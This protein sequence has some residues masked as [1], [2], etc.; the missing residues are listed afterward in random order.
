MGIETFGVPRDLAVVLEGGFRLVD[1]TARK[2]V[3]EWLDDERAT[4]LILSG[5]VGTG[6]TLAAAEAVAIFWDESW[7]AEP[8]SPKRRRA[9]PRWVTARDL[10]RYAPWDAPAEWS[11]AG[12][13]VL[14][15]L[16]IEEA[17]PQTLAHIDGLIVG[18][19]ADGL[20]TIITTNMAA[21]AK[22]PDDPPGFIDR[23]KNRITD[24]LR[25]SGLHRGKAR[26][27]VTCNGE[28]MRGRVEPTPPGDEG[29]EDA[30]VP[31]YVPPDELA[32]ATKKLAESD[33]TRTSLHV[34]KPPP[35]SVAAERRGKGAVADGDADARRKLR[36]QVEARLRE[37]QSD[38]DDE[39]QD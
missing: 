21:K 29:L 12:L 16:G 23:Y 32:K 5:T 26:Y 2:A 14:D 25:A 28:S 10:G 1:T 37:S 15:D 39:G 8:F 38:G 11:T 3:R 18:R 7:R 36:A 35:G 31:D 30:D 34:A 20:R 13:L 4:M 24:R 33:K 6:K 27:W 22:G 19:E 9:M 17:K